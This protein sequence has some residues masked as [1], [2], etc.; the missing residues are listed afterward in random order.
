MIFKKN[1]GV[2]KVFLITLFHI[3]Q[4]GHHT[5]VSLTG[6]HPLIVVNTVVSVDV[7]LCCVVRKTF[8]LFLSLDCFSV[9]CV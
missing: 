4:A 6:P 9:H 3:C 8:I 7:R 5:N 2:C 1:W